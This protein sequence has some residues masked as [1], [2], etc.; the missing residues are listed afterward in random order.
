M[1]VI[2][3]LLK[4][5]LFSDLLLS[6]ISVK[7]LPN[8]GPYAIL[9]V[10]LFGLNIS[11]HWVEFNTVTA[12]RHLIESAYIPS[13]QHLTVQTAQTCGL[14]R[15]IHPI[16]KPASGQTSIWN[17]KP[18]NWD[19]HDQHSDFSKLGSIKVVQ[20]NLTKMWSVRFRKELFMKLPQ[21]RLKP[22]HPYQFPGII[23]YYL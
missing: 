9:F 5:N 20:L 8:F 17:T 11:L 18:A 1:S 10:C 13:D 16:F 14:G 19:D 22:D 15:S 4:Y 21:T 2:E 23:D 7:S 12:G 3:I 6:Q